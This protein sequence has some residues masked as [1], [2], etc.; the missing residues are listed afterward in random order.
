MKK[1]S[2][3]I[4]LFFNICVCFAQTPP[5]TLYD[6]YPSPFEI[7]DFV[8]VCPDTP[9]DTIRSSA[10]FTTE[11]SGN[12][13]V[14]IIFPEGVVPV[15]VDSGETVRLDTMYLDSGQ[16]YTKEY[17]LFAATEGISGVE[18]LIKHR[19]EYPDEVVDYAQ[20]IDIFDS[21]LRPV[22]L[23]GEDE[24]DDCIGTKTE[25]IQAIGG[26]GGPT[27]FN[28]SGRVVF[29]DWKEPSTTSNY[30][31]EKSAFNVV[32]LWFRKDPY[33]LFRNYYHPVELNNGE[34]I[35]GVHYAVCDDDGYFNFNFSINQNLN[36]GENWS[37]DIR[38][39]KEN[40]A[41][42]LF[43]GSEHYKVYM[44]D[45]SVQRIHIG[46]KKKKS[47]TL[48]PSLISYNFNFNDDPI[49]LYC[50]EGYIYRH[51][52]IAR[53]FIHTRFGGTAPF[54]IPQL[55]ANLLDEGSRNNY[56]DYQNYQY[57]N[58]QKRYKRI[59]YHE[60]GHYIQHA[61]EN[62]IGR[63]NGSTIAYEGW[64]DFFSDNV[65]S[66]A[67]NMYDEVIYINETLEASPFFYDES[68]QRYGH[69]AKADNTY[70]IKYLMLA[71]FL[72]NLYD[73]YGVSVY[74]AQVFGDM[75]NDD[76][77]GYDQ[78]IYD[79]FEEYFRT[80]SNDNIPAGQYDH[81]ALYNEIKNSI[82]GN[83]LEL[84]HSIEKNI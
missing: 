6:E 40:E 25:I 65:D 59:I 31:R 4:I 47:F 41:I 16:V 7:I 35:E 23:I 12:A 34:Y 77:S 51:A 18:F 28:I 33:L 50:D 81:V 69:W 29:H 61:M 60:Y 54:D 64:A 9:Y 58:I 67:H 38:V 53:R 68:G 82:A 27:T 71:S 42:E 30:P 45:N 15:D 19:G 46:D 32:R 24:N 21:R 80:H 39:C 66:W 78:E 56:H 43:S 72:E 44:A 84:N 73:G 10:T 13:L 22:I 26:T 36:T 70:Q 79:F 63:L 74:K 76:I 52:E 37:L 20:N 75:E 11:V 17:Y 14:G 57:I 48:D 1:I 83:D 3:Y 2:V 5:D 49:I 55:D 62:F 8:T